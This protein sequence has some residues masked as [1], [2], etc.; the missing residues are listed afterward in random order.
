MLPARVSFGHGLER[1]ANV[2]IDVTYKI[3]GRTGR[4]GPGVYV[5]QSILK[6]GKRLREFTMYRR[7]EREKNGQ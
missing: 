4:S 7:I 6:L 3:S 5:P 1:V 2:S